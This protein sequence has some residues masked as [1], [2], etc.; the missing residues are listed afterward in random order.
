MGFWEDLGGAFE[1]GAK[2]MGLTN[3]S[4]AIAARQDYGGVP[5]GAAAEANRASTVADQ[6]AN[7]LIGT[8]GDQSNAIYNAGNKFVDTGKALGYNDRLSAEG[9][10]ATGARL[11]D[12]T[13]YA[14]SNANGASS[15]AQT[16]A[17]GDYGTQL[18]DRQQSVDALSRL[19]GFL[20]AGPGPSAAQAQL[21]SQSD[22]NMGSAIALARSGRGAGDNAGAMRQAAFQN[23]A[24][25]QATN[26]QA[27]QLRAQED[28]AWKDKQMQGMGLEQNT[29]GAMRGQDLSSMGTNQQTG[30]G[31]GNLALGNT[32]AGNNAQLGFS[33]V[34]QGYSGQAD[35]AQ[36]GYA[37]L[38]GNMY[39]T[40]AQTNLGYRNLASN[41]EMAGDQNRN[42]IYKAQLGS[43]TNISTAQVQSDIAN[44]QQA[45][46]KHK[47]NI[48]MVGTVIGGILSD[49]REKKNIGSYGLDESLDPWGRSSDDDLEKQ[50]EDAPNGGGGLLGGILG[51]GGGGMLGGLLSDVRNKKNIESS[52]AD[53]VFGRAQPPMAALDDAYARA[54]RD[55][56]PRFDMRPARGYSYEYK[57]PEA[58]GA[59]PGRQFGPMAQDLERSPTT[60]PA[61]STGP[62]GRKRVDAGRLTMANTAAISEQQRVIDR[63]KAMLDEGYGKQQRDTAPRF[64]MGGAG[65]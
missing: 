61:V 40:G 13:R 39:N 60:A 15:A 18:H 21:R 27:A 1:Q 50:R 51:G 44:Q 20:D 7:A 16:A 58:P 2:D 23:A 62:D 5:G 36:L 32:S 43:D 37:N 56:G 57:N 63:L 55:T 17:T 6:R 9:A 45:N 46:Q 31:Y 34:A 65:Y 47:D 25:G 19:R 48:G 30:L 38:A 28:A 49:E 64:A 12:Q 11:G 8:G 4:K 52:E 26:Q 41:Q 53:A 42:D 33:N 29:L 24:T 3:A 14:A 59:A 54:G 35:N 10:A 22:A